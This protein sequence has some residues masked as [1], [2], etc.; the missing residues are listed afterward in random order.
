MR[1]C[2][3]SESGIAEIG[4]FPNEGSDIRELSKQLDNSSFWKT[5]L[6]KDRICR[7]ILDELSQREF[8]PMTALLILTKFY[9]PGGFN[10]HNNGEEELY[11]AIKVA[12]WAS[13]LNRV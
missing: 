3:V 4:V 11:I 6:G 5:E 1:N 12:C 8:M 7:E 9:R 2:C 10:D 13:I